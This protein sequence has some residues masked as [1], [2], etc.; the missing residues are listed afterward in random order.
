MPLKTDFM[1]TLRDHFRLPFVSIDKS[2]ESLKL[3]QEK[4]KENE[5]LKS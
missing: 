3:V 1:K 2:L 5:E 4:E